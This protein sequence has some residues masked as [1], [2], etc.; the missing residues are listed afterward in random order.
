MISDITSTAKSLNNTTW[1]TSS[2]T[3]SLRQLFKLF[4]LA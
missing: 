1:K 2:S 4:P 3:A